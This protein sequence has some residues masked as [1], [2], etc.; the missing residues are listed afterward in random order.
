MDRA[1][2]NQA[3]QVLKKGKKKHAKD[4]S[5]RQKQAEKKR[6]R[7]EKAL[8]NSAAIISELEKKR[9]QKQE[10]QQR[11]DDEGAAIAEAVALHVLIGEDCDEPCQLMLNNRKRC[12]GFLNLELT[13]GAQGAGDGGYLC[14]SRLARGSHAHVPQWRWTDCG[15]FSFSSWEEVGDFEALYRRGAFAQSDSDTCPDHVAAWAVSP[16]QGGVGSCEDAFPVQG[17]AASAINIMLSDTTTTS[18]LNIYRE[19]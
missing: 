17:A 14:G 13:P 11:L 5:D 16:L 9:R 8:A 1:G 15:P 4:E 7:L 3:G 2:G 6:R 10:E 12:D 19:L 18:S